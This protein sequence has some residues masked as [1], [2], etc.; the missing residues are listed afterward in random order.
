MGCDGVGVS[1]GTSSGPLNE[2]FLFVYGE[3]LSKVLLK[4]FQHPDS[5]QV[6]VKK[7]GFHSW[8]NRW[9][10]IICNVVETSFGF[11]EELFNFVEEKNL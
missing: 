4:S 8:T 9:C 5:M 3:G 2:E 1:T 11:F 7:R 10:T 6:D